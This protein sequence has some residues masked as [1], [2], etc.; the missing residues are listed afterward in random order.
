M[1]VILFQIEV[2]N[3]FFVSIYIKKSSTAIRVC[4][5]AVEKVGGGGALIP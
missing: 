3:C 4:F 1:A 5:K 2:N